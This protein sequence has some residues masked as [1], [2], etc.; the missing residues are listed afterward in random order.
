MCIRDRYNS[1]YDDPRDPNFYNQYLQGTSMSCPNL[2][3][4]MALYLQSQPN[5]TRAQ[6]R[7]WLLTHGSVDVSDSDATSLTPGFYDPYQSNSAT[8]PTYWGSNYG[9]RS[10]KRRVLLNPF[11]NNGKASMVGIAVTG[12]SFSH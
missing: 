2:A 1:G 9:L 7:K 6:A 4:V 12:I 10:S 3:G 5:A 8:D 11:C